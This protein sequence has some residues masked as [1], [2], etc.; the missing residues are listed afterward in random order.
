MYDEFG[1][2]KKKFRAKSRVGDPHVA[3][4]LATG[5]MGKAGWDMEELGVSEQSKERNKDR[6]GFRDDNDTDANRGGRNYYQN[7]PSARSSQRSY[8]SGRDTRRGVDEWNVREPG[9]RNLERELS[10]FSV[11]NQD[12]VSSEAWPWERE[13][14]AV[15]GRRGTECV[16]DSENDQRGRK[17][18]RERDRILD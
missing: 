15:R 16:I 1:Y 8:E 14:F 4:A 7:V 11:E 9:H 5:G 2:L 10:G 6:G 17:R 18:L 13:R 12:R 3:A